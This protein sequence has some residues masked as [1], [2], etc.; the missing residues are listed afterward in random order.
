MKIKINDE[1]Y[2]KTINR[3]G[4]TSFY[5]LGEKSEFMFGVETK[6]IQDK[7]HIR[8]LAIRNA[9]LFMGAEYD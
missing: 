2:V 8:N 3:N 6:D 1:Y 9:L 7:E 4:V 5:L